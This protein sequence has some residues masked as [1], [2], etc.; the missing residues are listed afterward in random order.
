MCVPGTHI[1]QKGALDPMELDLWLTVSHKVASWKQIC[2]LCKNKFSYPLTVFL[3]CVKNFFIPTIFD[4][5]IKG[6]LICQSIIFFL[7]LPLQIFGCQYHGL[8]SNLQ[9]SS[10]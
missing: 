5:S 10:V 2:F 1:S 8:D 6:I 3:D 9:N 7:F 4:T